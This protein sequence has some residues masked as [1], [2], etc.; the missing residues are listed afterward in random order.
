MATTVANQ[1]SYLKNLA[2]TG[3]AGQK[4]W[5]NAQLKDVSKSASTYT[6]ADYSK[7]TP[8]PNA[9]EAKKQAQLSAIVSGGVSTIN[10][11][12]LTSDGG[13]W[14]LD[15]K[16]VTDPYAQVISQVKVDPN[17]VTA[18]VNG[19]TPQYINTV[20]DNATSSKTT[21][22]QTPIVSPTIPSGVGGATSLSGVVGSTGYGEQD[23][24]DLYGE[25]LKGQ[26]DYIKAGTDA[27]VADIEAQKKGIPSVYDALRSQAYTTGRLGAIG[28]NEQLAQQGL[29]GALYDVP[30]SGYSETSRIGQNISM[31]NAINK[32]TSEQQTAVNDLDQQILKAKASG[33][34]EL[35]RI[36]SENKANLMQAI[37]DK[38]QADFE[39]A[40]KQQEEAFKTQVDTV[41]QYYNDFQAEINRRMAIDPNDPL[42][43]YLKMAKQ[44]KLASQAEASAKAEQTAYE[45]WYD[46]QKLKQEDERIAISQQN[47]NKSSSSSSSSSEVNNYGLTSTEMATV[48]KLAEADSVNLETG[49]PDP[50]KYYANEE[51][52]AQDAL[53]RKNGTTSKKQELI[54][55]WW[56]DKK[57]NDDFIAKVKSKIANGTI[58]EQDYQYWST[59]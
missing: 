59:R 44:D 11:Q 33:N 54:Q 49:K 15:G 21:P 18:L 30:M 5:A 13:G 41:G 20:R 36:A 35:A 16:K 46:E 38:K 56:E 2:S 27:T 39:Y 23:I 4:A 12:K 28:N 37:M 48:K 22:T 1:T 24:R 50:T 7:G 3:T 58:T 43:P 55:T 29:A 6:S 9:T 47:A 32:L 51:K 19:T 8:A 52:Y 40:Q 53:L 17:F 26:Q 42:I 10:G 57:T 14:Y 25:T 34:A 45:R 31:Q